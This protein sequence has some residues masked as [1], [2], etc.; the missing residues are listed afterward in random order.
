MTPGDAP[1]L[2]PL[3]ALMGYMIAGLL[4][5]LLFPWIGAETVHPSAVWSALRD[6][7]SALGLIFWHQRVPRVGL[8]FLVGGSLALTGAALQVL[9]RNPL[10]EPWT[11][12]VSGGA[13]IGTFLALLVPGVSFSFGLLNTGQL[14]AL[15]GAAVTMGL[16]W[17]LAHRAGTLTHH[18][19][20]LAG[21]TISIIS[22]GLIMLLTYFVSP[23]QFVSF[24][25]WMMG[26]LD[27][28]GYREIGSL[29]LLGA[30]GVIVLGSLAREYN[31]LSFSEELALGQGVDVRRVQRLTFVGAGLATAACVSVAGP[32][33]F[34]GMIVPH[35]VR[36]LSGADHRIVLPAAFL[37][38]GAVLVIADAFARTIIAPTEIPVGIITAV[39]GGPLFLYL[40]TR[41]G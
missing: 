4:A 24:H 33:A 28:I 36:R 35:A 40:L 8:A 27:V 15:A 11:L 37:L 16:V 10:A 41:R 7:E 6:E 34:V 29:L 21:V 25:R 3:K 38:G 1:T 18:T 30:P 5:L 23:F 39:I 26:G 12:G 31:H 14:A 13:A 22:G 19:L 2:R 17:S 9:F 20:L 32:I